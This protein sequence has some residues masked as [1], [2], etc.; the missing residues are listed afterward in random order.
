MHLAVRNHAVTQAVEQYEIRVT[1]RANGARLH[2]AVRNLD[3]ALIVRQNIA[4]LTG[5]ALT[6]SLVSAERNNCVADVL[7]EQKAL[8]ALAASIGAL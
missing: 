1:L 7:E 6:S 2:R 8:C 5:G 4:A 3:E